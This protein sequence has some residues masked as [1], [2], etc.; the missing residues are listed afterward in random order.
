MIENP[1]AQNARP[2]IAKVAKF[3][4]KMLIA[5]LEPCRPA[6]S[7]AKPGFMWITSTAHISR[8]KVSSAYASSAIDSPCARRDAEQRCRDDERGP[9]PEDRG[10]RMRDLLGWPRR[11]RRPGCAPGASGWRQGQA[12]PAGCQAYAC[13]ARHRRTICALRA[14][15]HVPM[16]RSGVC[17]RHHAPTP[18]PRPGVVG[19]RAPGPGPARSAALLLQFDAAH[20]ADDHAVRARAGGRARDRPRPRRSGCP[21]C[22]RRRRGS[23]CRRRRPRTRSRRARA[24]TPSPRS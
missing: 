7:S 19:A 17:E 5:F 6:S 21:G 14:W 9:D 3:F 23:S 11:R 4:M 22:G 15:C 2:A 16:A 8:A 1:T 12:R 10:E 24:R 18:A 13:A 20:V